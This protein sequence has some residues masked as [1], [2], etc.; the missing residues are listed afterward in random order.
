MIK[1]LAGKRKWTSGWDRWSQLLLCFYFY[2]P[3]LYKVI[4]SSFPHC[5]FYIQ[6]SFITLVSILF[7]LSFEVFLHCN[8]FVCF[9]H[10][11][12]YYTSGWQENSLQDFFK[13]VCLLA[14]FCFLLVL[15]LD[16]QKF[17]A[18]KQNWY[19]SWGRSITGCFYLF[20]VVVVLTVN[21]CI[22]DKK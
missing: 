2:V 11:F 20:F 1:G 22:L 8:F 14:L 13:L 21:L 5:F 19:C 4:I 7:F 18:T 12:T 17:N 6:P 10:F 16:A 9:Y 3:I 15:R